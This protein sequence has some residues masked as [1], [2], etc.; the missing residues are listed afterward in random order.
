MSILSYFVQAYFHQDWRDEWSS[1]LDAVRA[2]DQSEPTENKQALK[3]AL[4]AMLKEGD[5]GQGAINELGGNFR[6]ETEQLSTREWIERVLA[7][8]E[9]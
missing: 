2:F 5:L 6:P 1:S 9:Q 7:T 3:E 8:I 4:R